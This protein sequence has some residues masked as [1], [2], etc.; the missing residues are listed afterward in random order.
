VLA[1]ESAALLC[2]VT[3][4]RSIAKVFIDVLGRRIARNDTACRLRLLDQVVS[5]VSVDTRPAGRRLVDEPAEGVVLEAE[6][7]KRLL[8]FVA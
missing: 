3:E 6:S 5:V 2:E 1:I 7:V 8:R 4:P